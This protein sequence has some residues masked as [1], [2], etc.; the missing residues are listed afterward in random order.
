MRRFVQLFEELN[1]SNRTQH[2]IDAL[3]AYFQES[4][5]RDAIWA[6]YFLTGRKLKSLTPSKNLRAWVAELS[7][8]PLW[9]IDRSYEVAGDLAET[10]S[11]VLPE[12]SKHDTAQESRPLHEVVERVL[13]PL[14]DRS[15]ASKF[16]QLRDQW[17]IM[18]LDERFVFN[19]LITGGLRQGVSRTLVERALAKALELPEATVT[20]R[21]TGDW[22]PN[23]STWE[24]L[25]SR[26]VGG[27]DDAAP[28]AF[29]LA[30][31]LEE[32]SV[33][34]DGKNTDTAFQKLLELGPISEWQIEWKWDG[35]RAQMIR[36]KGV[37]MLWSR[38]EE[39]VHEMFPELTT[40]AESLPEGT[41]LDGEIV[42]SREGGVGSFSDLQ[43]RIG[44]KG[45]SESI[46]RD[47]PCAFIAYDLL[48][49]EGKDMRDVALDQRRERLEEAISA[50][51]VS[52]NL[53]QDSSM[54]YQIDFFSELDDS[55]E[56]IGLS[57]LQCSETLSLS[58]WEEAVS[59]RE[60]ARER[61]VE[62]FMLKRKCSVYRSGRV[63]GDWWKWKLDPYTVDCVLLYA[64]A[65]HGKRAGLF[66]DYTFGVRDG[67]DLVP[68]AKA[69]SGLT[70]ADIQKVDAWVKKNTLSK[71]GPVR[72]VVAELVFEVAFENIHFSDRHRSGLALRFPRIV[73]LRPDKL[74]KEIDTL[75]SLRALVSE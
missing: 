26:E 43:H 51:D 47:Y 68:V 40:I 64:Q 63:K 34:I 50:I 37:V 75:E 11:L 1:A 33:A 2:K 71:K 72:M 73:R 53:G 69:Y 46:L 29:C 16:E 23:L 30:Y 6:L 55:K 42:I 67:E 5:P 54:G 59:L 60:S 20:H 19:K 8:L 49:W 17:Q 15:E 62:G 41:V 44:R 25:C 74:A 38:G 57:R 7:G 35:I 12:H 32:R 58:S 14:Q 3:R 56:S 22:S 27:L 65:G 4:E 36:R 10:L 48:E 52:K 28:Y 24:L 70:K 61:R 18:T 66:T 45:V 9:L 13:I 21:L 39:R 31:P